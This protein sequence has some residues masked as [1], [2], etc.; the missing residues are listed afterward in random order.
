MNTRKLF[1]PCPATLILFF[2]LLLPSLFCL[3]CV[4][5]LEPVWEQGSGD[6]SLAPTD[7]T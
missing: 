1:E 3:V 2:V 6:L 7:A 5:L 4:F